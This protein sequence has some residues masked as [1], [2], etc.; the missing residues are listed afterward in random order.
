MKNKI[1]IIEDEKKL[2]TL[3]SDYLKSIGFITLSAY[4]GVTGLKIVEQQKPDL[5][6][7]DIMLP[8]IDGIDITRR[9]REYSDI[10]II[11]YRFPWRR[12]PHQ[13]WPQYQCLH[14]HQNLRHGCVPMLPHQKIPSIWQPTPAP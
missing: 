1:L 12:L 13:S 4:D 7:L 5:I 10:P 9:I 8:V 2:N 6:V 14:L 11:H 3:I